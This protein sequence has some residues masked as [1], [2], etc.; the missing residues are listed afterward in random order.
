MYCEMYMQVLFYGRTNIYIALHKG[1]VVHTFS[2]ID[3]LQFGKK[4]NKHCTQIEAI[5][6][7][8]RFQ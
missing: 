8:K 3:F 5:N 1:N 6:F 4:L 7:Q 2:E